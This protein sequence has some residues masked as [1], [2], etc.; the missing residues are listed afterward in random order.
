MEQQY[1]SF[2]YQLSG[3]H[4]SFSFQFSFCQFLCDLSLLSVLCLTRHPLELTFVL[5][6]SFSSLPSARSGDKQR[7][8]LTPL[9]RDQPPGV[10]GMRKFLLCIGDWRRSRGKWKREKGQKGENQHLCFFGCPTRHDS[11]DRNRR[12]GNQTKIGLRTGWRFVHIS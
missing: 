9:R 5:S 12:P 2:C 10:V 6:F 11:A 3:L 1:P 8:S 4:L 7:P